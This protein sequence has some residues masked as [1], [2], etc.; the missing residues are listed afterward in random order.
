[1]GDRNFLVPGFN[2][3]GQNNIDNQGGI[4]GPDNDPVINDLVTSFTSPGTFNRT[5][6]TAKLL[7]VAGGGGAANRGG[8]G[9]AG[10]VRYFAS[11]PLPSS[12][13]PVDVGSGGAGDGP[14]P[15]TNASGGGSTFGSA[16]PISTSGGGR[17]GCR[18]YP[19]GQNTNPRGPGSPTGS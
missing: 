4:V 11:H 2:K 10:G 5:A 15:F 18:P 6:T 1:M 3:A 19:P 9:G 7:V 14:S 12:S 8:G 16:T 13:V 17:G